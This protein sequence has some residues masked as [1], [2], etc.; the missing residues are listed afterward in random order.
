MNM[1]TNLKIKN[2]K[3]IVDY[4]FEFKPFTSPTITLS[5]TS[6]ILL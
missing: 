6:S 3:S 1:F 5:V 4:D 2:F